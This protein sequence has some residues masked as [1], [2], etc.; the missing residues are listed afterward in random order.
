MKF[1]T[2]EANQ[3]YSTGRFVVEKRTWMD[4][5]VAFKMNKVWVLYDSEAKK[6]YEFK[7]KKSA[8]DFAKRVVAFEER[9]Q[10]ESL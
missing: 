8:M 10:N 6:H 7:G 2:N 5:D 9:K 3:C 4:N 1:I